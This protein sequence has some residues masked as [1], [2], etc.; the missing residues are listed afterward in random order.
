MS[1][2]L[3]PRRRAESLSSG[4]AVGLLALTALTLVYISFLFEREA[5]TVLLGTFGTSNIFPGSPVTL[6]EALAF[7]LNGAKIGL[8][9]VIVQMSVVDGRWALMPRL[10][11]ILILIL[12]LLMTLVIVSG[13]TISPQAEAR[14]EAFR[15]EAT[16]NHEAE[17]TV[18]GDETAQQ[19]ARI[20]ERFAAETTA[21]RNTSATRIAEW[22]AQRDVERGI[23]GQDFKGTRYEDLE[24]LILDEQNSSAK[25]LDELR[26]EELAATTAITQEA[27]GKRTSLEQKLTDTL[28]KTDFDTVYASSEAQNPYI[29]KFVTVLRQFIESNAVNPVLMT[30]GLSV[31]I[32]LLIEVTPM[33]FFGYLYRN[34]T[35]TQAPD[36]GENEGSAVNPAEAAVPENAWP[37]EERATSQAKT[38]EKE[39]A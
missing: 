14:L 17:L 1:N 29:L 16:D 24:R 36:E 2:V 10:L 11:R 32:S 38:S 31:L 28:S 33:T 9:F 21:V 18:L 7:G 35:V 4:F 8:P 13:Q 12:S 22:N 27:T 37:P 39:A 3:R 6:A 23:G 15:T 30:I 25:R 26:R 34:F 20:T 19:L 5:F